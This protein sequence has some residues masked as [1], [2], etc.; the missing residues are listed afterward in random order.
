MM[1]RVYRSGSATS[2]TI[3]TSAVKVAR[4]RLRFLPAF[5]V[6]FLLIASVSADN[7]W[8]Q[9][10]GPNGNGT[11][12]STSLPITWN[13]QTG[14]NV[15]WKVELPSWSGSTPVIWGDNIFL[16]SPSKSDGSAPPP[17]ESAG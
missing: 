15:A 5:T 9:W 6:C 17:Q 10:R 1:R 3:R 13:P 8:P 12:D 4:L 14:E 2:V 11:S 7:N 16:T